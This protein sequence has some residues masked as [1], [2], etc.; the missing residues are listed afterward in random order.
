MITFGGRCMRIDDILFKYDRK[1]SLLGLAT[2][3]HPPE[4]INLWAFIDEACCLEVIV[5]CVIE[6]AE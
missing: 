4:I 2:G 6:V 3:D 1:W 5:G